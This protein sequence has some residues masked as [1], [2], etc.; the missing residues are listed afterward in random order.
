MDKA[1]KPRTGS[2]TVR[3]IDPDIWLRIRK[4]ALERGCLTGKIV[5]QALAAWLLEYQKGEKK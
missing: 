5:N 3:D 4:A 2:V 1:M